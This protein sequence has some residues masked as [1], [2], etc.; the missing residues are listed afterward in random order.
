MKPPCLGKSCFPL[1]RS[2]NT[3]RVSSVCRLYLR[4]VSIPHLLPAVAHHVDL[5]DAEP[6]EKDCDRHHCNDNPPVDA[7]PKIADGRL[8]IRHPGI[9]LLDPCGDGRQLP[10]EIGH[11]GHN[12]YGDF[13]GES[14]CVP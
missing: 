14:A 11:T 8:G 10:I 9:K 3:W 1:T 12:P 5:R 6:Y 7:S 2:T 13:W 4:C